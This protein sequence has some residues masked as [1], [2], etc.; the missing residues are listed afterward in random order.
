MVLVPLVAT[1]TG[2]CAE[3]GRKLFAQAG[4]RATR[5]TASLKTAAGD[6][7]AASSATTTSAVAPSGVAES[8]PAEDDFEDYE[9]DDGKANPAGSDD[10]P[11]RG[12]VEAQSL[13]IAIVLDDDSSMSSP[14]MCGTT[15]VF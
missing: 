4:P 11:Y 8:S 13:R 10:D 9:K 6:E 5:Q 2:A 7:A 15:I 1:M 12:V 14:S 3:A